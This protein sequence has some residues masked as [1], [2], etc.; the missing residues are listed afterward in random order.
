VA[1][2]PLKISPYNCPIHL[3]QLNSSHRHQMLPPRRCNPS[4]R[5]FPAF[6]AIPYST[7]PHQFY[8][9]RF[10]CF[11]FN[12]SRSSFSLALHFRLSTPTRR[13]FKLG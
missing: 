3:L 10:T 2:L 8:S 1:L 5:S 7:H 12:S 9:I 13:I 4:A 11:R 6:S